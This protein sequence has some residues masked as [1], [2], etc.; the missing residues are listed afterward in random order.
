GR[1]GL[2]AGPIM[3]SSDF[4]RI[5]VKGRQ[6]H[7]AMPWRGIDPVVIASQIVLGLQTVASRQIDVLGSPSVVSI[8]TIHGGDRNNIIPD[9]VELTGTIRT[10]DPAVRAEYHER[11]TRTAESIAAAAGAT[12]EVYIG[13]DT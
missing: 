12:A 6:T 5:T 9:E 1:I 8:G 4:L 13:A 10:F 3:A 11:I 7:A 2:R